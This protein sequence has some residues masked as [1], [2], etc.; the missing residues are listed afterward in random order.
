MQLDY[1]SEVAAAI[2]GVLRFAA[3]HETPD[4]PRVAEPLGFD[5]PG[6]DI[7]AAMPR[8]AA[9]DYLRELGRDEEADRVQLHDGPLLLHD[10]KVKRA[11]YTT[12]PTFERYRDVMN[13][14]N[15][16]YPEYTPR[17]EIESRYEADDEYPIPE[18]HERIHYHDDTGEPQIS[19]DVH[20]RDFGAELAHTIESEHAAQHGSDD[21]DD[22]LSLLIDRLRHAPAIEPLDD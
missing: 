8:F 1:H 13:H 22:T 14:L 4:S 20:A 6:T 5:V 12:E 9:A 11:T 15:E 21:Y 7:H 17:H 18:D 16:Y 3:A 2:S 19:E 10:G